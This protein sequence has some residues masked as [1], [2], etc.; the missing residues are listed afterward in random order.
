MLIKS[1]LK[2]ESGNILILF[3]LTF[4]FLVGFIS[5]AA[6]VGLMYAERSRLLEIGNL[7]RDARFQQSEIIWNASNPAY[8]F[9]SLVREYGIKNGLTN[10]QIK[11]VYTAV[12]NSTTTRRANVDIILT[13]TYKCTTLRIFGYNEI[14]IKEVIN[15]SG[16][17]IRS[18]KVWT[19]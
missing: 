7:M 1:L 3:A 10:D 5:I 17:K 2:K 8:S 19:P 18:P 11:T 12:E 15:G 6:D 14:T 4:T 13:S 9:D 16:Y